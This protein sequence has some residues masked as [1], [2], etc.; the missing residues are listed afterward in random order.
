MKITAAR[1]KE[2]GL[3]LEGG[4]WVPSIHV[5]EM[6]KIVGI[7]EEIVEARRLAAAAESQRPSAGALRTRLVEAFISTGLT[8]AQAEIAAGNKR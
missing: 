1:A 8:A 7:P 4:L 6:H 2:L 5:K 3:V